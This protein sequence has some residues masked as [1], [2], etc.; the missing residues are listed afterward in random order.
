[1]STTVSALKEQ[2]LGDR[3]TKRHMNDTTMQKAQN[4]DSREKNQFVYMF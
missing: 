3:H 2:R 4:S 1:M